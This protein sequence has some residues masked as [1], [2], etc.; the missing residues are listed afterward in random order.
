M[1]HT[2][3][4]ELRKLL[5]GTN[6]Q[7]RRVGQ[8][9]YHYYRTLIFWMQKGRPLFATTQAWSAGG[10]AIFRGLTVTLEPLTPWAR[11]TRLRVYLAGFLEQLADDLER[12]DHMLVPFLRWMETIFPELTE[13]IREEDATSKI[14]DYDLAR[15]LASLFAS[16]ADAPRSEVVQALRTCAEGFRTEG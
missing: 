16:I 2:L 11:D 14:Y 10:A 8:A 1:P 3:D 7:R 6:D 12:G 4:H 15:E 9:L 13:I 5:I